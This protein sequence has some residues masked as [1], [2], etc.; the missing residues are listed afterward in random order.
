MTISWST[1]EQAQYNL[2]HEFIDLFL[3]PRQAFAVDKDYPGMA[4]MDGLI[5]GRFNSLDLPV[6][7]LVHVEQLLEESTWEAFPSRI[8]DWAT[9]YGYDVL[10]G[11]G[12]GLASNLQGAAFEGLKQLAGTWGLYLAHELER[13][14]HRYEAF[15]TFGDFFGDVASLLLQIPDKE[16]GGAFRESIT[17]AWLRAHE[18]VA[19]EF[20]LLNNNETRMRESLEILLASDADLERGIAYI[21]S[22]CSSRQL[23]RQSKRIMVEAISQ[24]REVFSS[25]GFREQFLN[26]GTSA[27]R[28][29]SW[30]AGRRLYLNLQHDPQS[31]VR[32]LQAVNFHKE[33]AAVFEQY[34]YRYGWQGDRNE[35]VRLAWQAVGPKYFGLPRNVEAIKLDDGQEKLIGTAQGLEGYTG[36]NRAIHAL[37]DAF[38]DKLGA[39]LMTAAKNQETDYM[40]K[41][42]TDGMRALTDAKH[43]A[44]LRHPDSEEDEDLS[45]D[46]ILSREKEKYRASG[47]PIVEELEFKETVEE[48]YNSLTE[49]E[50]TVTNLKSAGHTEAEIAKMMG[51]SQQRVSQLLQQ[52]LRKYQKLK[53]HQ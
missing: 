1:W 9:L 24:L 11:F 26:V 3:L 53:I 42:T 37:T 33:I 22:G 27:G 16:L 48:W 35:A 17:P 4:G 51:I 36:K 44:D 7:K 5:K 30:Y 29:V 12:R 10:Q 41:Q 25:N 6:T 2:V 34:R 45:D 47:D 8:S 28:W 14:F 52:C 32:L 40:R 50:R 21:F 15:R 43:T 38:L 31:A 18:T 19:Y 49:S 20:A 23:G 13:V 46:E 39:Y